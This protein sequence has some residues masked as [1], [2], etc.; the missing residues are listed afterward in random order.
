VIQFG[1][2]GYSALLL[3][4]WDKPLYTIGAGAISVNAA[5]DLPLEPLAQTVLLQRIFGFFPNQNKPPKLWLG[6]KGLVAE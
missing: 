3:Q 5:L 1:I 4:P 6:C 2:L